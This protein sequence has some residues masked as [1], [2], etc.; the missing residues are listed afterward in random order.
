[1]EVLVATRGGGCRLAVW[2]ML[3]GSV[4]AVPPRTGRTGCT[5]RRIVYAP[6][7]SLQESYQQRRE[8]HATAQRDN[9]YGTN[10]FGRT[11]AR[12]KESAPGSQPPTRQLTAPEYAPPTQD[13][14]LG[15]RGNPP[16]LDHRRAAA[17]ALR[18]YA[19]SPISSALGHPPRHAWLGVLSP[20]R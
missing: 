14:P 5:A 3:H 17:A 19:R 11:A 12:S 10:Q 15:P 8:Q 1:M 4:R 13:G 7:L 16:P 9:L 20:S 18:A 6:P 2:R